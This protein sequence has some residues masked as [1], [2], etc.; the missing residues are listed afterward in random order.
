MEDQPARISEILHP[1]MDAAVTLARD[2]AT[3]DEALRALREVE[4]AV[5]LATDRLMHQHLARA[6]G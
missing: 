2:F 1:V 4:V 6:R 5:E 3:A